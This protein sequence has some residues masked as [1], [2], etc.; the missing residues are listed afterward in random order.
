M[1]I[2]RTELISYLIDDYKAGKELTDQDKMQIYIEIMGLP[3][4]TPNVSP[5]KVE[6]TLISHFLTAPESAN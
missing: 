6:K 4:N 2:S 1:D 3:L 5:E